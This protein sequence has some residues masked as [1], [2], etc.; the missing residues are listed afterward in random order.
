MRDEEPDARELD[1]RPGDRRAR[2]LACRVRQD[3]EVL[4]GRADDAAHLDRGRRLRAADHRE[5]LD[6]D[7]DRL[8]NRERGAAGDEDRRRPVAADAKRAR[9][10]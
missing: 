9:A 4:Q 7:G 2:L 8:L 5:V 10:A 3:D 6:G 1:R